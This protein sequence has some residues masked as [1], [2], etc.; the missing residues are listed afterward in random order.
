MCASVCGGAEQR[1]N[2]SERSLGSSSCWD[3]AERAG[4]L[5]ERSVSSCRRCRASESVLVRKLGGIPDI[6][7]PQSPCK[8]ERC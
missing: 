1:S 6:T 4:R 2:E 8:E 5:A 7:P 3:A